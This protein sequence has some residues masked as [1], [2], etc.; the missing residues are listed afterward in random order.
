MEKGRGQGILGSIVEEALEEARIPN[1]G[2][3]CY[4]KVSIN[5]RA[6]DI[7]G[8]MATKTIESFVEKNG[9]AIKEEY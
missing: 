9:N 3:F 1:E 7:H 6:V 4:K 5:K 8:T 2:I